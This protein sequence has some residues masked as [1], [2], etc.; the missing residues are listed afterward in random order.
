MYLDMAVRWKRWSDTANVSE[1]ERRG[2]AAFFKSIA[3]RFGLVQKFKE[4]G[5]IS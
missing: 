5:V 1:S 2:I 4:I 3:K